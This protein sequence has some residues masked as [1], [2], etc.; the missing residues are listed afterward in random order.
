VE[1]DEQESPVLQAL[2]EGSYSV[3]KDDWRNMIDSEVAQ[4]LRKYR[5]N[6]G[7]SVRD[8]LRAL[9]NKVSVRYFL[10]IIFRC[11]VTDC[12]KEYTQLYSGWHTVFLK[13]RH[14]RS[15]QTVIDTSFK[16]L[17]LNCKLLVIHPIL[18]ILE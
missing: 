13:N 7:K 2:E 4:D 3:V 6:R 9:R 12:W 14:L 17:H 5:K 10:L 8:L 11:S 15:W 18:V 16:C 1:K